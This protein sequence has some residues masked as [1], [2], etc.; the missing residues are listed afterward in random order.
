MYYQASGKPAQAQQLYEELLKD[1]E[2]DA[3]IPKHLVSEEMTSMVHCSVTSAEGVHMYI[4]RSGSENT[5][6]TQQLPSSW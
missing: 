5:S 4:R 1:Q 6:M 3:T 2:H